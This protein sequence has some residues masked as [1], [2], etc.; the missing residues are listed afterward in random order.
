MKIKTDTRY[1]LKSMVEKKFG[2]KIEYK[3]FQSQIKNRGYFVVKTDNNTVKIYTPVLA[4]I[5]TSKQVPVIEDLQKATTIN[6]YDYLETYINGYRRGEQYFE[7][8]FKITPTTLYGVNADKYIKDI[9][10]NYFQIQHK[11]S[12]QGWG[13]VKNRCPLIITHKVVEEFG[14]YSGIVNKI[15]E[16]VEKHPRLFASFDKF[17]H[18]T[19]HNQ[20]NEKETPTKKIIL[21]TFENMDHKGWE[22]AFQS[23]NDYN[24]FVQIL[25][26]FFEY[27]PFTLPESTIQLKRTCKT[28]IA[29]VLGEIHKELSEKP[30]SSDREYF[31]IARLLNHFKKESDSSLTRSMQR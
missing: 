18:D 16:Q 29:K 10:L 14:Y 20:I 26:C 25:T 11:P 3:H 24:F 23:L 9:Q 17:E 28:K 27:K 1:W 15:D 5:L 13:H 19:H 30:L 31:D 12:Y 21:S 22:Y 6:G 4:S 8:E 7:K 2:N